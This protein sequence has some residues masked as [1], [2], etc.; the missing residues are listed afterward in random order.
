ME[1][2]EYYEEDGEIVINLAELRSDIFKGIRKYWWSGLILVALMAGLAV[3]IKWRS[4]T[5]MYQAKASF[6]IETKLASMVNTEEEEYGFNYDRGTASLMAN[7]FPYVVSSSAM[8][9]ILKEKLQMDTINGTITATAIKNTNI[10]TIS[11]IS[12]N[13]QDAYNVVNAI[14]E[15]YPEIAKYVIGDTQ[16]NMIQEPLKPEL[17]YN[18]LALGKWA[19][20]GGLAGLGIWCLLVLI[21]AITR[22]TIRQESDIQKKLNKHCFGMLPIVKLD[23]KKSGE[24]TLLNIFEKR[25]GF[26]E[27]INRIVTR[28]LKDLKSEND[29]IIVVTS[30]APNEGK[31]TVTVNIAVILSQ[32]GN[33]VLLVDADLHKQNLSV[34]AANGYSFGLVDYYEDRV[35]AEEIIYHSEELNC[36]IITGQKN[37]DVSSAAVL[38]SKKTGDLLKKLSAEYDYILIDTPPC[39][40]L[41]DAVEISRYADS[42]IFVIRHDY[43]QVSH[44]MESMQNLY[45]SRIRIAGC[46]I[47]GVSEN[48]GSYGYG[49]YGYGKYGY[50]KYGYGKYGY[51]KYGYGK[52]GSDN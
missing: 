33:S 42:A 22:K 13:A 25:S 7:A 45:D 17:P 18:D 29:K 47:N 16:L 30:T 9:D 32:R 43:E 12:D 40:L 52:Y 8:Q 15:D 38:S 34:Y 21:Y 2:K 14:V 3:L 23:R 26:R 10:F 51:G 1:K 35:S 46:I 31:T 19:L 6:T 24:H 5:P 11:V 44:I 49:K 27:S 39:E 50:G 28:I 41:S 4:Y 36:D 37:Y 20:F 48:T